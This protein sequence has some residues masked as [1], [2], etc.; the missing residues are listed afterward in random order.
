MVGTLTLCVLVIGMFIAYATLRPR[1]Y[2]P[3]RDFAAEFRS[4]MLEH[5]AFGDPAENRW[6]LFD[7]VLRLKFEAEQAAIAAHN[8]GVPRI[9]YDSII[10]N[11][12]RLATFRPAATAAI[13]T[14]TRTGVFDLLAE[15]ARDPRVVPPEASNRVSIDALVPEDQELRN[16]TR[17]VNVRFRQSIDRNDVEGAIAAM[18]AKMAIARVS[19]GAPTLTCHFLGQAI[20]LWIQRDAI[21][22]ARLPDIA[23]ADIARIMEIVQPPPDIE[24]TL[25]GERLWVLEQISKTP[26]S[27]IPFV[28]PN[29]ARDSVDLELYF[30]LCL[31]F[32][33]GEPTPQLRDGETPEEWAERRFLKSSTASMFAPAIEGFLAASRLGNAEFAGTLTCLALE[34][35]HAEHSRYPAALTELI[36]DILPELPASPFDPNG[37]VYR[38]PS[39]ENDLDGRAYLLYSIGADGIDNGGI[40]HPEGGHFGLV[41]DKGAGYDFVF[42]R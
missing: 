19:Y 2:D 39:A 4:L 42:G 11:D 9:A 6:A 34:A 38:L 13:E 17:A 37:L 41:K 14:M 20:D 26:P 21:E 16:L 29:P 33:R 28:G 36:P 8:P 15:L 23:R 31:A 22:V 27:P 24:Y 32:A 10:D 25:H 1:P 35:F 12:E 5:A 30:D 7:Q 40:E 3:Y 18:K